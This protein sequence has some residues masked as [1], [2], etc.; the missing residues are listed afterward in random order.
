MFIKSGKLWRRSVVLCSRECYP[1]FIG[2]QKHL[3]ARI[4]RTPPALPDPAGQLAAEAKELVDQECSLR[5]EEG[6][7]HWDSTKSG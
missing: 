3:R 5:T 2:V 6:E 4:L 7:D 1:G